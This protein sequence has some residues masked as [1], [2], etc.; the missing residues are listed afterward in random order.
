MNKKI[1]LAI[2]LLFILALCAIGSIYLGG[3]MQ[4]HKAGVH[5]SSLTFNTF[6]EI[7]EA[8]GQDSAYKKIIAF[9]WI[10]FA[11]P[12]AVFLFLMVTV[13]IG[14]LPKKIIYGDARLATPMDLA[15][16]GFFPKK[17]DKQ[18]YPPI[19]IGKMF[20][21]RFKNNYIYF[22][23]QQF[24]ILYAPTRSGKGVGIVIPN[25]VNYYDS[26]VVLDIKLEN[27]FLSAGYRQ[28]Q[29]HECYL[30]SP[31]GFAENA[32]A[33][34]KGEIKSHRL[35]PLDYVSRSPLQRETD[36]K[37]IA[38][39]LYPMS[40]GDNDTWNESASSLWIG[41]ALYLLDME[42]VEPTKVAC[43][44]IIK[45]SIPS[46]GDPLEKWMDL[47]IKA[48]GEL[49]GEDTKQYF[50]K[51]MSAADRTRASILVNFNN[52]MAVFSNPVTAAATDASDFD[53]RDLR[54]KR[55]SVYLGLSPNSL[56]T[57]AKLVNL[58]FSLL[59]NENTKELPENNP[60]LKYQCL[61]ILDEFTS[62]G[63]VEIIQK[64]VGFTAG[65]NIRF[66]FILQNKGQLEDPK[67]YGKEGAETFIENT[68]V[69]LYY[70]PKSIND[71]AKSISEKIGVRDMKV[72]KHSDSRS[73]GKG[74][75]SRSRNHDVISR[76][77]LLPEEI[78]SLRDHKNKT[79]NM[80]VREIILSDYCRPFIANKI[81]YFEEPVFMERVNYA[82]NNPVSIPYLFNEEERKTFEASAMGISNVMNKPNLDVH[83][84][85]DCSE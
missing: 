33:A 10:G 79:G 14:L 77:V 63:R 4:L 75:S 59:V 3:Y 65:Y 26:I 32:S 78:V 42:K 30:F 56:V 49:L 74:G 47:T 43:S 71:T 22:Y 52:G 24:L 1:V 5:P 31:D 64:A 20:K 67:M 17:G 58:F 66:M 37:K 44:Q 21:G 12:Y 39:I 9:G 41:L 62:M 36:L 72:T 8:F 13:I 38:A 46:S 76:A 29:G 40:G 54:K 34:S 61:L 70:P 81:I 27:F 51:F 15:R 23:G 19:L 57:H 2:F 80:A 18:K 53:L 84:T 73:S 85:V 16:S 68:G 25:C 60:E 50:R 45:T 35:N 7:N 55:M 82:K 69:E 6:F 11:I 83:D 28:S 48:K